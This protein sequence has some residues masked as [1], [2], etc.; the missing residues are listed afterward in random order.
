MRQPTNLHFKAIDTIPMQG[1]G[2]WFRQYFETFP[3]AEDMM[4]QP[5][6]M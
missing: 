5:E 2:K 3:K 1:F 6:K 4:I